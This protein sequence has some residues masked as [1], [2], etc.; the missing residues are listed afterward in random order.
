MEISKSFVAFSGIYELYYAKYTARG[1]F[2]STLISASHDDISCKR[3]KKYS[4]QNVYEK[5]SVDARIQKR[6]HIVN[7]LR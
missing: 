6:P 4:Y 2:I 5:Y 3:V 7:V 1:V